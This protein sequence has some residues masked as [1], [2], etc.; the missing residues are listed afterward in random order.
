M[1]ISKIR[2][3]YNVDPTPLKPPPNGHGPGANLYE[4]DLNFPGSETQHSTHSLHTYVAAINPPLARA[5]IKAF[6]PS[7][8]TLLDPFCGGGGVLVEAM[9]QGLP[10]AGNDINPLAA[11]ISKAKT[12][13]LDRP[14]ALDELS[15]LQ[16][17]TVRFIPEM[18]DEVDPTI[19]YWFLGRTISPIRA[20][21]RS[22]AEAQESFRPFF[23]AI[24]SAT[25]RDV[26]LTYRGEV[27]LR[28]LREAD[29]LRFRPDVLLTFQRRALLGI[30]RV[31]SLP[32]EIKCNVSLE[33]TRKLS[34][35]D[36][37]FSTIVCSPPYGDDTNGVG[38]FQFSRNMLYF[39]GY[40]LEE[41]S[42]HRRAFLGG[43]NAAH[44]SL[45]PSEYLLKAVEQIEIV[46][47]RLAKDAISFYSDYSKALAEMVR[48]VSDRVVI[49][50]GNRVLG[51][52]VLDNAK[53]SLELMNQNGARLE[54]YYQRVF[55]KKRIPNLGSDGG[56]SNVEHVLVFRK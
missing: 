31:A 7:G 20:L 16:N 55:R 13:Y 2:E 44:L 27:R 34:V 21:A 56:G 37:R 26:M 9:L 5:L 28:R 19:A 49:V 51:R 12:T 25:V 29:L 50:I 53:I 11:E 39:L 6:V 36:G 24:L 23:R 35:E 52:T 4:M 48:V 40:P 8:G 15:A 14:A 33:D 43:V 10:S 30:D 3:I 22:I 17:R 18:S 46:S 42:R 45:P 38:Y 32:R 47:P 41:I 54:Y 1:P